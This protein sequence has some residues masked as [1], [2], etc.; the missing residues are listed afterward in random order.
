[1]IHKIYRI[2]S[3]FGIFG[4]WQQWSKVPPYEKSERIK[5]IE[6]VRMDDVKLKAVDIEQI[7]HLIDEA[8]SMNPDCSVYQ[9]VASEFNRKHFT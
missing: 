8:E 7:C 5:C 4:K 9:W 2:I 3:N 1:M 6:Y